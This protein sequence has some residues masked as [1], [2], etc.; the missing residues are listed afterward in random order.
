MGSCGLGHASRSGAA[1]DVLGPDRLMAG[2]AGDGLVKRRATAVVHEERGR[3][4]QGVPP[5]APT[6]QGNKSRGEVCS[7]GGEAV[8]VAYRSVLVGDAVHDLELDQALQT[9]APAVGDHPKTSLFEAYDALLP[10]GGWK[11]WSVIL[12]GLLGTIAVVGISAAL[13]RAIAPGTTGTNEPS[14]D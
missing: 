2:G 14:R 6:H 5:V 8:L 1:S 11:L 4:V 12:S 13:G 10:H 3:T 7:L 9:S